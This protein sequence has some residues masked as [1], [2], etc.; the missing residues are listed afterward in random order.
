MPQYRCRVADNDGSVKIVIR[1]ADNRHALQRELETEGLFA[2]AI[3]ESEGSPGRRRLRLPQV[4]EF[5]ETLAHL[6]NGGL[7]LQDAL[8]VGQEVFTKRNLGELNSHLLDQLRKGHSFSEGLENAHFR[9]PQLLLGLV[10]IGERIGSL[11]AILPELARYFD[12]S[13]RVRDKLRGAMVYPLLV[14][15]VAFAGMI[16]VSTIVLPRMSEIFSS[17]GTE[18]PPE[19]EGALAIAS[20]VG[21]TLPILTLLT[22]F[23]LLGLLVMRN[24]SVSFRRSIDRIVIKTP[25]LGRFILHRDSLLFSFAM[26][27]LS[28]G[29]ITL[30]DGLEEASHVVGN[31][32]YKD[33]LYAANEAING[34][35]LVSTAFGKTLVPGRVKAW[36]TI[37]ERTGRVQAVF[38]QLRSYFQYEVEQW[39][40]RFVTLVEPVLIILVGVLILLM[41]IFF[42]IPLFSTMGNLV[43]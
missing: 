26:E 11:E 27:I 43:F 5:A 29:G 42:V 22:I 18:V 23:T 14:L 28:S 34:G 40:N 36:I 33:S 13:K 41:V 7:N 39:A 8:A 9:F 30:S 2:V 1:T 6:V 15:S 3:E 20:A 32:A 37:G 12:Q 35:S 31:Q 16:A 21:F 10:R 17:I 25:I 38:S 24:R 4:V 19:V